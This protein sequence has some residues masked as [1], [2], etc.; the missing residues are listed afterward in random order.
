MDLDWLNQQEQ[1][2][3]V[4]HVEAE[5]ASKL[6][7]KEGR[8]WRKPEVVQYMRD[9]CNIIN[10]DNSLAAAILLFN[11]LRMY[12][13]NRVPAPETVEDLKAQ[14]K[15]LWSWTVGHVRNLLTT[16][17]TPSTEILNLNLILPKLDGNAHIPACLLKHMLILLR[18]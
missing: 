9:W 10:K 3:K 4:A 16:C 18:G 17:V 14:E 2:A 11:M 6:T 13:V 1:R 8:D 7:I 5:Q 15:D 12:F